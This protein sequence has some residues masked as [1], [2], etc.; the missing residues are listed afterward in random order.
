MKDIE[1]LQDIMLFVNEF[2]TSV[3]KDEELSPIFYQH[4]AGDWQPHMERMYLF[5]NA[6]LFGHKGYIG[7]PFAK[8]A[9]MSI[10]ANHFER[11]LFWFNKIIDA[12]FIGPV[13]KEAK[14]RAQIMA[15]TFQRR[16]SEAGHVGAKTIV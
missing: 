16:L 15:N 11:W 3:Q 7:N 9:R 13:S 12:H 6:A 10:D 8:H 5:W 14:R 2:Y 1:G 4:I